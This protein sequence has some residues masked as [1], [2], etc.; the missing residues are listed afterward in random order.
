MASSKGLAGHLMRDGMK[1]PFPLDSFLEETF[2]A[3]TPISPIPSRSTLLR[4]GC[5][6]RSNSELHAVQALGVFHFDD[7]ITFA[8]RSCSPV[9]LGNDIQK[10]SLVAF[11]PLTSPNWASST[12]SGSQYADAYTPSTKHK[13]T[14]AAARPLSKS[15][16]CED[17][18][19]AIGTRVSTKS[20]SNRDECLKRNR[21]AAKR[22]REKRKFQNEQLKLKFEEQS[23]L[24]RKLLANTYQLRSVLSE[25]RNE[26]LKHW[27]CQDERLA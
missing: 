15:K 13:K 10:S 3:P 26:A 19:T 1:H 8:Q 9:L 24:H 20:T 5:G 11:K 21:N 4:E 6:F 25:L 17:A 27:Q 22:F 12:L 23:A 7:D 18:R 14:E 2:I 16:S